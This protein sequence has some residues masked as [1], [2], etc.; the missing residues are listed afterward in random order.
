[1]MNFT[2]NEEHDMIEVNGLDE[3]RAAVGQERRVATGTR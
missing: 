2:A 1:M 3:L